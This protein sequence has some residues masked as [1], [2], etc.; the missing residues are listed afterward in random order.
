MK[1]GTMVVVAA[2]AAAVPAAAQQANA[3]VDAR[4]GFFGVNLSCSTCYILRADGRVAYAVRPSITSVTRGGPADQAGLA[5]G[6]TLVAA[7]GLDLLTPEGFER[8][9]MV[10]TGQ[11]LRLTVRRN[12]QSRD[13]TVVLGANPSNTSPQEYYASALRTARR[14]G[15]EAYRS[16]FRSPMG[17]LGMGLECEECSVA[18]GLRPVARFRT[19]PTVL[20]VD[21]DG[22]AHRAGLRRG[23]TLLAING[24]DL[25]STEG[26]R[27]F[28]SIDPG[29]RV[30]LTARR[31]GR[32][33]QVRL[34]AVARPDAAPEEVAAYE[35]YRRGR[36]SLQS[37]YRASVTE[38]LQRAQAEMRALEQYMRAAEIDRATL[39]SSRKRISTID[40]ALRALR[41][42]ER[43]LAGTYSGAITVA[44]P[45]VAVAPVPPPAGWAAPAPPAPGGYTFA[46]PTPAPLRYSGRL[47]DLVNVE[48]RAP[49]AVNV[50]EIGDTVI[51]V[52][53]GEMVVRITQRPVGAA[54]PAPAAAPSPAAAPRPARP[55]RP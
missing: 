3:N 53:A 50:S 17:W 39:D 31:D 16:A 23:D 51:V 46:S 45:A 13:V 43:Q 11:S 18:F 36:D 15:L 4:R 2:L 30:T 27:A 7:D 35:A 5:R 25:T 9:A 44:P 10:T 40:S 26:G 47:G 29:Q 19:P 21:V 8:F 34:V 32:E 14:Q 38:A 24:M 52:T 37:E 12:G 28:A 41:A 6:D 1:I 42:A 48:A 49:G 33:R 22:P 54:A 55:A 20:T